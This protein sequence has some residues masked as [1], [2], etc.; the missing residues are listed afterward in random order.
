MT[1]EDNEWLFVH[2]ALVYIRL[3]FSMHWDGRGYDVSPIYSWP[4][5]LCPDMTFQ[6]SIGGPLRPYAVVVP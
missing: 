3:G 4:W 1:R 5:P 6:C 2:L